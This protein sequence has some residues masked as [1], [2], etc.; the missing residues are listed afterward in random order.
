MKKWRLCLLCL[1]L[2]PAAALAD[3]V[4]ALGMTVDASAEVLDFDAAG[5]QVTDADALEAVIAQMPALK[6]VLLFDSSL[7]REDME[8]LFD[9][10]PDIFFGFTIHF[11]IH[12]V[13]TDATAF[14]TLHYSELKDKNDDYHRSDVLSVLRLCKR[15]KALDLG[16]NKLTDLSFLE[17]LTELRVLIISPNYPLKDLSSLAGLTKLEYLE[18]FSTDTVDVSPLAGLVELRDLNLA[19]SDWLK[20]ISPLYDLPKLERFWCGRGDVPKKQQKQMEALHP[21]CQFDWVSLPTRGGWREHPRYDVIA[22]MF[23]GTEYIPFEE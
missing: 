3:T 18:A 6:E 23:A 13:R 4:D 16:H 10:H 12:T 9:A 5:I 21:D 7:P 19:C 2:L 1:L 20:D 11:S 14:S 17:G 15:L 22:E 8:R